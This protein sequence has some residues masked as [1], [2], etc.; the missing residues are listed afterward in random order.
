[1]L[2]ALFDRIREYKDIQTVEVGDRT[3]SNVN[4]KWVNPKELD[5]PGALTVH[6]LSGLAD[7]IRLDAPHLNKDIEINNDLPFIHVVDFNKVALRGKV[8]PANENRRYCYAEATLRD[9]S[10]NFGT[11]MELENF[12]IALQSEFVPSETIE[13]ILD[14]L[15][16]LANEH[17]MENKDDGFSQTIQVRT[18][19]TTKSKVTI[20]NPLI[21]KP[22]RTFRELEQPESA[23]ILRLRKDDHG[24]K[25]GLWEADGDEWKLKAI[26]RIHEWFKEELPEMKLIA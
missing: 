4:L 7:Y 1:M 17:V 26:N 3:Y 16:N 20:E 19:I 10:F 24:L 25:A 5:G 15:G 6:T 9:S 2:K 14:Y 11:W 23:C 21:L 18:G 8:D 13:T 22:W 12:I